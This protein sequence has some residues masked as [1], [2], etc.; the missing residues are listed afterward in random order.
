MFPSNALTKHLI[1]TR[2]FLDLNVNFIKKLH[3]SLFAKI[4]QVHLSLTKWANNGN[5]LSFMLELWFVTSACTWW[6]QAGCAQTARAE[7]QPLIYSYLCFYFGAALGKGFATLRNL[8]KCPFWD[9]I[10]NA[11]FIGL[12]FYSVIVSESPICSTYVEITSISLI[13]S[14]KK[15]LLFWRAQ[16]LNRLTCAAHHISGDS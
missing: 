12:Q 9:K 13:F 16:D 4:F 11:V 7:K 8:L 6:K 14:G 2:H 10:G 5:Q 3:C 15:D 1:E